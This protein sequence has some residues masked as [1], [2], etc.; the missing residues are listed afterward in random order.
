MEEYIDTKEKEEFTGTSSIDSES[1]ISVNEDTDNMVIH[2]YRLDIVGNI[3]FGLFIIQT[4]GQIAFMIMMTANYYSNHSYFRGSGEVQSSTFIGMYYI[5]FFWFAG[6]AV[7]RHRLLNFFRLRC[8]YDQGQYVQVERAEPAMIFLQDQTDAVMDFVRYLEKTAKH[9]IGTD[10]MVTILPLKKTSNGTKYFIYQCTRYVYSPEMDQF[11]PHKFHLGTTH[12]E[13]A[14]LVD[15]LSTQ[16]ANSREELVGPNFIEVYVPNFVVALFQEFSSF[17][18]IYQF[19]VLWLF[20]YLD[21][22]K[23]LLLNR[24]KQR[25][26][27]MH[28]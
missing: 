1:N 10:I 9:M 24:N 16:E 4:L 21:Y 11:R 25:T 28:I 7:F 20:Y 17:F 2:A 15:G 14:N 23:F 8:D 26:K 12:S 3:A 27:Y 18:Y 5:Y 13:L 6:I 22:C 19:T